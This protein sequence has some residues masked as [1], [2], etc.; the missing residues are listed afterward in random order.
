[1]AIVAGIAARD[2]RQVLPGRD[3]TVVTGSANADYLR[4]VD[5]IDRHEYV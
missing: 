1:M 2:V 3:D 5:G 4:M